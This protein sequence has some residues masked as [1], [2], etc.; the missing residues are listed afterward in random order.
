MEL[1]SGSCHEL[2]MTTIT[3]WRLSVTLHG[4]MY[5]VHYICETVSAL[6]P[7]C[8]PFYSFGS[9]P[10]SIHGWPSCVYK[11][12][13]AI[14]PFHYFYILI[15]CSMNHGHIPFILFGNQISYN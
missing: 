7:V 5:E 15:G 8:A 9:E 10:I 14:E 11:A 4:T 6:V 1:V 2:E 13:S 12:L 3:K